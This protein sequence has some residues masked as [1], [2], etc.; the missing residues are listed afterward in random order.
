[1]IRTICKDVLFL[2][3]K[4]AP[5]TAEDLPAVCWKRWRPMRTAAWAWRQI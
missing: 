3:R 4:S 1:M 2:A 5:A